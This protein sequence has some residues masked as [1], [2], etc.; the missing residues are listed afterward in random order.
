MIP[1]EY[2]KSANGSDLMIETIFGSSLS[3]FSAE[4][5][6]SLRGLTFNYLICDEFAFFNNSEQLWNEVLFPTVKV[7]GK[8]VIFVS[9]PAGKNNIFHKMYVRGLSGKAE[10]NHYAS[11]RKTIYDDGLI[12]SDEIENI[13]AQIPPLAFKQEFMVEFLDSSL[14]YFSG[15]EECFKDYVYNRSEKQWGGI[16]LSTVGEDDTI[17]TFINESKQTIQYNIKGTLDQKYRQI[18]ELLNNT[19]GLQKV[20]I[21]SNGVGAPMI[22]EIR[23]LVKNQGLIHEWTTTNESKVNILSNLALKISRKEISFGNDNKTLYSQFSTFIYKYTKTGKLQLEAQ[24][25]SHDDTVL[26]LGMA[27]ECQSSGLSSGTYNFRFGLR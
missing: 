8:K 20:Y 24:S 15:F 6:D 10:Y 1:R 13:K 27:L 4:S 21:E 16:D 7:K 17:V 12:G 14:T 25:G 5:G 18:A 23:K 22:N 19:P 9:T 26:S 2:V 3:M 11:L